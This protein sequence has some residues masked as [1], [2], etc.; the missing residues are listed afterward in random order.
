MSIQYLSPTL[1]VALISAPVQAQQIGQ[2]GTSPGQLDA[3]ATIGITVPLG[4]RRGDIT[5]RP[6]AELRLGQPVGTSPLQPRETLSAVGLRGTD[7]LPQ[8]PS[9]LAV[10]FGGRPIWTAAG[11]V[12]NAAPDETPEDDDGI[13]TG[14]GIGIGVG[15]ALLIAVAI[16]IPSFLA[17]QDSC[18]SGRDC[19]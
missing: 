1:I 9:A 19:S 16:A 3:R 12:L 5:S 2:Y 11:R 13:D 6:R 8:A 18:P 10:T 14:E 4:G 15:V 7:S 17:L